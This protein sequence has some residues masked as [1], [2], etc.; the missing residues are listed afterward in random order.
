MKLSL[1]IF[2]IQLSK[3]HWLLG[4][5]SQLSIENKLLLYKAI[6]KSIWTYGIQFWGTAFNTNMEI[7]QRFQNKYLKII[8]NLDT[9]SMILYTTIST[10][11]TLETRLKSSEIRRQIGETARHTSD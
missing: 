9:S 7:I 2:G 5:K 1:F 3:M 4:S 6:L 10:Y 11:H 8:V